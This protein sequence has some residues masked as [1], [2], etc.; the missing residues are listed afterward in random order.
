[1]VQITGNLTD[2]MGNPLVGA[3]I[4]VTSEDNRNTLCGL[5]GSITTGTGG[6]YDFTLKEDL[7]FIEVCFN[8]KEWVKTGK[9][10]TTGASGII[11]LETLFTLYEV[12]D[13]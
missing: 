2:P 3:V 11:D 12:Q 8:R 4:R 9:V 6:S 7:L 5:D 10:D 13:V 1:M